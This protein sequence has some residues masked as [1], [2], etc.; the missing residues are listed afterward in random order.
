MK[1][2]KSNDA[3]NAKTSA[4]GF[5][6]LKCEAL[7]GSKSRISSDFEYEVASSSKICSRV[8]SVEDEMSSADKE[9][10]GSLDFR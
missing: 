9:S 6:N 10:R 5:Q 2:T 3:Y 4:G 7:V 8:L 1:T